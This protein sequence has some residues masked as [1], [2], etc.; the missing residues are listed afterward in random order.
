MDLPFQS[1]QE[2]A[3]GF[4]PRCKISSVSDGG[5]LGGSMLDLASSLLGAPQ[6]DPW[7]NHLRSIEL[8]LAPAP[9]LSTARLQLA[10]GAESPA[11]ALGD[12]FK[13]ELGYDDELQGVFTGKVL[14]LRDNGRD[15]R[16]ILLGCA[17]HA[18]AQM[19]QYV[20]FENQSLGDVLNQWA[21]EAAL[22]TGSIDAGPSYPFL[23]IDDRRTLWEWSALLAAHAG[24]WVW[25]DADNKL[26][27]KQPGEPGNRSYAY[28]TNLLGLSFI[29]RT[30][31]FGEIKVSGEGSAGSQGAQA[32]SW[33]A[34][35]PDT[36]SATAGQGDPARLYQDGALRNQAA[37]QAYSRALETSAQQLRNAVQ[38]RV[39]GSAELGLGQTF[40]LTDCPAGRGDGSYII[41]RLRHRYDNRG[42]VTE[43]DGVAA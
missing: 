15:V 22:D 11:V 31:L 39:P 41:T 5:G 10:Y 33:L 37:V 9:F 32:W 12:E 23:A 27:C 18:L 34:K 24:A 16:E 38:A 13:L 8:E 20:S 40:D 14:I 21:S 1:Q 25:A 3:P 29:E 35:S 7:A 30:G 4:R 43:L 36:I 6:D 42:F 19:R 26:N 17:G 28:G 2:T